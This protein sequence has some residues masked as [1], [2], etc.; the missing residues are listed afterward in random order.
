[1]VQAVALLVPLLVPLLI[2]VAVVMVVKVL[3]P[4]QMTVMQW[5]RGVRFER[6]GCLR[7]WGRAGTG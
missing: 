4:R 1:M 7:C 3:R 6:G 5:E 2:V